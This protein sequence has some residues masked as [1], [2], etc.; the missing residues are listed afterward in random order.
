MQHA[1]GDFCQA[2]AQALPAP[3]DA[4]GSAPLVQQR[5]VLAALRTLAQFD[6]S[7]SFL[8]AG[9]ARPVDL[10]DTFNA[11]ERH[12]FVHLYQEGPFLLDPFFR[13]ASERREGFWRMRELA[14]DRFY[15]SDY[16]HSYYVQTGLAEEVGFFVPLPGGATLAL[17]LMRLTQSRVFS[18]RDVAQLRQA[19]P[20]VIAV[21]KA[22]WGEAVASVAG[23]GRAP[24][25]K[26]A[27][28]RDA[29]PVAAAAAAAGWRALQL[30]AREASIMDMVLQGH[31][32][33]A[34]AQ[35]L[36][37]AR[38]TVKVHR[39]NAYSK[40]GIGSQAEL[41]ATYMNRVLGRSIPSG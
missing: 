32:T 39:R 14:P 6:H 37:V 1:F 9:N 23:A 13:A 8:Y 40:L 21:L 4:A 3:G 34:I 27:K 24:A 25:G 18:S 31:S 11:A 35:R 16:F 33:D 28:P 17:S 12:V 7:V 20:L 29:L 36:A 19:A 22:C 15:S 38:V 41:L 30:T 5:G 26:P 2:L 10:H